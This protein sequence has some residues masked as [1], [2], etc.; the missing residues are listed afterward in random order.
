MGRIDGKR[1]LLTIKTGMTRN[2]WTRIE[3]LRAMWSN[4]T[5]V[6]AGTRQR[7]IWGKACTSDRR[8][9]VRWTK[10]RRRICESMG[11]GRGSQVWGR[12]GLV[13]MYW[14]LSREIRLDLILG[15]HLKSRHVLGNPGSIRALICRRW[16]WSQWQTASM[17]RTRSS[18]RC[19]SA[20]SY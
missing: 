10:C 17:R 2:W 5:R 13:A 4:R 14:M 12:R 8:Y 20:F 19:D 18:R 7:T 16:L 9:G 15:T 3:W 11:R 1:G 6:V